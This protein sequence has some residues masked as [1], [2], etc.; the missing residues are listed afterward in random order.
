MMRSNSFPIRRREASECL[1]KVPIHNSKGEQVALP[2]LILVLVLVLGAH[3]RA[4]AST[5]ASISQIPE[6]QNRS[7]C[8]ANASKLCTERK[9]ESAGVC[10][11]IGHARR[12]LAHAYF[13][14]TFDL[15][16][17]ILR[18]Y[19]GSWCSL[20]GALRCF[21]SWVLDSGFWMRGFSSRREGVE[22]DAEEMSCACGCR[23]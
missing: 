1:H 3:A 2:S 20:L 9:G 21:I 5:R 22:S 7:T 10:A 15:A 16:R 11:L 12:R 14:A 6:Q 23:Q 17:A 8:Q 19:L 13:G 4:H 18:G